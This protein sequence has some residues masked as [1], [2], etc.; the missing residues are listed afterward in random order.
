MLSALKMNSRV[1]IQPV[2]RDV[3]QT[4]AQNIFACMI[5]ECYTWC[6]IPTIIVQI[7]EQSGACGS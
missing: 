1:T 7:A 6:Q 5:T 2:A 3:V 4:T